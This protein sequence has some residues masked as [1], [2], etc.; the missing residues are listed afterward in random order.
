MPHG[1]STSPE[2]TVEPE[3]FRIL[4]LGRLRYRAA[5][6]HS[7]RLRTRA[8]AP[9]RTLPGAGRESQTTVRFNRLLWDMNS[10]LRADESWLPVESNVFKNALVPSDAPRYIGEGMARWIWSW[11]LCGNRADKK[12]ICSVVR[13]PLLIRTKLIH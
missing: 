12:L 4:I 7:G 8:V 2:F 5:C 6:P 1:W 13:V 10:A 11:I 3:L 9:K